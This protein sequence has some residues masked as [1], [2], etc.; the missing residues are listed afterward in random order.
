LALLA[1]T[2]HGEKALSELEL[3]E[4]VV[5]H[6]ARFFPSGWAN[7]DTARAGTLRLVPREA[8]LSVLSADYEKMKPKPMIFN[9][10]PPFT[11]IIERLQI[12]E[13]RINEGE[14]H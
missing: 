4:T 1:D 12:L 8:S 9:D 6:K 3:L 10:A 7:Y 13:R 11:T 14:G 5:P 2:S